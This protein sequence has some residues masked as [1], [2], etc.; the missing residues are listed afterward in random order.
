MSHFSVLVIGNDPEKQLAP[1]HQFECTD[2][3]DEYVQ[4]IDVKDEYHEA[5][6]KR[7]INYIQAP[8]GSLHDPDSDQFY[9]MPTDKEQDI[10]NNNK[11]HQMSYASRQWDEGKPY[12]IKVYEIPAGW[13]N[14]KKPYHEQYSFVEFLKEY[15]SLNEYKFDET[16]DIYEKDKWGW[17]RTDNEGD[18]VECIRRTNPNYEW[19]WYQLGGRWKGFFK[20][21]E[22]AE[23]IQGTGL[24]SPK[25][26]DG[27]YD[28]LFKGAIDFDGMKSSV[29]E[30]SIQKF[31]QWQEILK[32]HE[33]PLGITLFL[34]KYK[35]GEITTEEARE[36]YLNQPAISAYRALN[37]FEFECPVENIGFSLE[38]YLHS[39]W[40]QSLAP[41]ALLIN[42]KW[43]EQKDID[44]FSKEEFNDNLLD[45][46]LWSSIDKKWSHYVWDVIQQ[47]S[48]NT[49]L[50]L[51]DCHI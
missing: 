14:L 47:Q 38:K 1:Y 49:L 4:S 17:F 18:V 30:S 39:E 21:K 10:L 20:A 5:Y 22:G 41:Y 28:A 44:D 51:F 36:Q 31:N 35:N 15:Y 2:N 48:D 34:Q 23:G 42:G 13:N 7:T 46:I 33:R 50:S 45:L 27:Y 26:Q 29:D 24:F 11:R 12:Y 25:A 19:D 40:V 16:P 32:T 3:V 9:R 37:K 43:I 6:L 8:D